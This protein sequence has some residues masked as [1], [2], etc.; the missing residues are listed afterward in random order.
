VALT[1]VSF[2]FDY[3][4]FSID[5]PGFDRAGYFIGP[6]FIALADTDGQSG[7]ATVSVNI[8]DQFGFRIETDDNTG[9]PGVFAVSTF[10]TS[11]ASGVPEPATFY[12]I[13]GTILAGIGFF[14]LQ[15]RGRR[16]G[17]QR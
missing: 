4:Y 15:N 5:L 12:L 8:G 17:I 6:T 10:T 14:R 11:A 16:K 9:E 13:P 2:Q 1:P 7:T 3:S